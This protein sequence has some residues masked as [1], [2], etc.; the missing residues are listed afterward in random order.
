MRHAAE[1]PY[2]HFLPA[3][4]LMGVSC[5]QLQKHPCTATPY[6]EQSSPCCPGMLHCR[7]HSQRSNLN[8]VHDPAVQLLPIAGCFVA[9]GFCV[10]HLGVSAAQVLLTGPRLTSS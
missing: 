1:Q 10:G 7:S 4:L 6:P 5:W 8:L 9:P 2:L 3:Q